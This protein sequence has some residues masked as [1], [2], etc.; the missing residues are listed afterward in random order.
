MELVVKNARLP[1]SGDVIADIA[2]SGGM[3]VAIEPNVTTGGPV[4]DAGGGSSH[5][6][7]SKAIFISTNHASS[8]DAPRHAAISKRRSTKRRKPRRLSHPRTSGYARQ[9]PWKRPFCTVPLTCARTS[10]SI[11]ASACAVSRGCS[12]GPGLCVGD[13]APNLRLPTRGPAQQSRYRRTD[14][15]GPQAWLRCGRCRA[16]HRFRSAWTDRSRLRDGERVRR[17]H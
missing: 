6:G 1:E 12:T 16:L 15:R 9:A 4:I 11:P 8:T 5:P 10:K 17:R 14:G 3:I 7:S 13:R 2:I